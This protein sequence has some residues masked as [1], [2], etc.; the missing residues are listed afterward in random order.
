[1]SPAT[2]LSL[3]LAVVLACSAA[4][5]AEPFTY[6]GALTEYG[7]PA[8]GR[9][10]FRLSF[11]DSERGG[12]AL[13][14][15]VTLDGVA[16]ENGAFETPIE[17]PPALMAS[18]HLWLAVEVRD[19]SGAFITLPERRAITAKAL[20]GGVC[21]DTLGNTGTNGATNFLGT[22][23]AQPLTLRVNNEVALRL[24]PNGTGTPNFI[25]GDENNS[26]AAGAP[27]S[28]I[29]GGSLNVV[30][31]TGG[32]VAGGVANVAGSFTADTG[33]AVSAFVGGGSNNRALAERAV[34]VGG[35]INAASGRNAVVPGGGLN[36]A[37]GDYSF[38]GGSGAKVR[39]Q[40]A[41]SSSSAC[42]SVGANP[43]PGGDAGTFV[44]A[45]RSSGAPF[46]STG[47]NQFLM[48]SVGGVG[49]N[50]NEVAGASLSVAASSTSTPLVRIFDPVPDQTAG[51]RVLIAENGATAA[52][53]Y[54][55]YDAFN[56][57]FNVGTNSG[58]A[59]TSVLR[60]PRGASRVGV[61]RVPTANALEV[62]GEA[63][64]S[65]AGSWLANSDARIKTDIAPIDGALDTLM[66]LRPVTFRYTAA[67]RAEHAD[68][69]D[70]R[71]YNV[72]AQEFAEV[73]P[74]AV[75]TSG[76]IVP[77][78][79]RSP[80]NEILQVDTY[81]ATITH[82]AATQELAARVEALTERVAELERER[83]GNGTHVHCN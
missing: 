81:P 15:P 37:G 55:D 31:D 77:H 9:Y 34:V 4:A 29:G 54:I 61:L 75:K 62:Q 59:D 74:D 1:M 38:A 26:I 33:D 3:A 47:P 49:I 67:Y 18:E 36:C 40:V 14:P 28:T 19:A 69:D 71:Y 64:K 41:G 30:N 70:R 48:R 6:R 7:A 12:A 63:S 80:D 60:F 8:Q 27:Q 20:E 25:G 23:D 83:D 50:T 42:V 32:T 39:Q 10:T 53:G 5:E 45:D 78:A 2:R 24:L 46:E 65:V 66:R 52:G 82:I 21:W 44:W 56:N 79:K 57:V 13:T 16:V 58:A 22:A 73:F 68:V 11:H 51:G 17:L 76:E 35:S 43:A 72:V